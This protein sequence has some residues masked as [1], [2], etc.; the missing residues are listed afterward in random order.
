MHE[1]LADWRLLADCNGVTDVDFFPPRG[2]AALDARAICLTCP[3]RWEC[4]AYAL[5][6]EHIG[7]WGG[8]TE[9]QRRRLRKVQL[10]E[11]FDAVKLRVLTEDE[12]LRKRIE[13]GF[14]PLP[15]VGRLPS[16]ISNAMT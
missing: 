5:P 9:R 13:A 1:V 2:V 11:D 6:K 8:T 12:R 15:D 14:G 7:V 3:V 10:A 16:D 4:L